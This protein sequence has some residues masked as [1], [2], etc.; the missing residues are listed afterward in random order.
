[1]AVLLD[2]LK[3]PPVPEKDDASGSQPSDYIHFR[4]INKILESLVG[5]YFDNRCDKEI[6][7]MVNQDKYFLKLNNEHERPKS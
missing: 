7:T 3:G 5:V 6:K 4:H 1:M 2:Y